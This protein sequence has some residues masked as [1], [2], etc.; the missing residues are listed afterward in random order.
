MFQAFSPL[1]VLETTAFNFLVVAN[2]RRALLSKK[3][4]SV[5]LSTQLTNSNFCDSSLP[6][7]RHLTVSSEANPFIRKKD[8]LLEW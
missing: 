1:S 3:H 4:D 7:Q 8:L 2:W 5:H 6:M